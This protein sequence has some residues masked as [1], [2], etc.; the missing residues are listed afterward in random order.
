MVLSFLFEFIVYLNRLSVVSNNCIYWKLIH[1]KILKSFDTTLDVEELNAAIEKYGE[2]NVVLVKKHW[3]KLLLPLCL[4]VLS[5]FTLF[6]MLYTIYIHT[7][8]EYKT[9][10]WILSILYIYTTF[11]R[12]VYVIFSI[13]VRILY[14]MK[15]DKQYIDKPFKADLKKKWFDKFMKRTLITF[16]VHVLVFIFNATF[17]F[18]FIH[19]TWLG[20]VAVSLWILFIDF[21]F[22]FLLNRVM[23]QLMEYEMT[24]NICTTEWVSTYTQK[25]FFKIDS[26]KIYSPTIK[27]I[28][29]TKEWLS[30]AL[31]QYWNLYI[32][33][34]W[35]LNDKWGKN[36]ELTYMPAPSELAKKLNSI[37]EEYR[38]THKDHITKHN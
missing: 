32:Y 31:F 37:I 9:E 28:K 30:W 8:D 3:I 21:I 23:Y 35:D 6:I 14:W 34:D 27:V 33:T 24:F 22:L 12:C 29:A 4:V 2:W 7:F 19:E 26:M 1:M 16:I 18:I 11:S 20:S 10:F 38:E 5:L 36:L 25:W 17:P 15:R 13:V